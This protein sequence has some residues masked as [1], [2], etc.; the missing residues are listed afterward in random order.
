MKDP[1]YFLVKVKANFS[2]I[3]DF[4]V[5]ESVGPDSWVPAWHTVGPGS[6]NELY[7]TWATPFPMINSIYS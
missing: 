7:A 6:G 5:L 3:Q 1:I 4:A 2:H